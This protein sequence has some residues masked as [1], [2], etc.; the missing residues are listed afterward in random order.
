[1]IKQPPLCAAPAQLEV[2][3]HRRR[4]M[5]SPLFHVGQGYPGCK[6]IRSA[7]AW[8]S[9]DDDSQTTAGTR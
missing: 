8:P 5:H 4:H 3:L 1:M 9:P 6:R 7:F 2:V